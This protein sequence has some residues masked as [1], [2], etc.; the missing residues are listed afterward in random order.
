M[1][2]PRL[3]RKTKKAITRWRESFYSRTPVRLDTRQQDRVERYFRFEARS[4]ARL[5]LIKKHF[6]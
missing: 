6:S 1:T 2:K 5:D 4:P 3:P